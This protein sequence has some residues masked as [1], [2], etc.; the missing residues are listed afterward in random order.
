MDTKTCPKCKIE[1]PKSE[2][3]KD[4]SKKDK[5]FYCCKPCDNLVNSKW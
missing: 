4:S 3:N 2:F 1:K 5:L